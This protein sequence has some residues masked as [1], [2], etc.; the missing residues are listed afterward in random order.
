MITTEQQIIT[1]KSRWN[2]KSAFAWWGFIRRWPVIPVFII[3]VMIIVGIF[4]PVIAPLHYRDQNLRFAEVPPIWMEDGSSER[5]LGGDVVG[6]D[7]LSRLIYGARITL[8]ISAVSLL[9]GA[10][11]GVT[12][13]LVAGYVGGWTDEIIMRVVDVWFAIP[14]LLLALIVVIVF[15]PSLSLILILLAFLTWAGFVRNIRAEVLILKNADYVSSA[16]VSG[17]S[18]LRIVLRHMLPGVFNTVLVLATLRVG[19]L[20]LAEASLSFL[21]AGIPAPTPAWGGMIADGRDSLDTSWWIAAFPGIAIM[22]VVMSMNFL[23]DWLRDKLDPK[24]RQV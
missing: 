21:G 9:S 1:Q 23:G 15:G 5:I 3:G 19:S 8:M 12:A 22:L 14:F 11:I 20:I 6:R 18:V 2:A 13:G 10:V 4:A 7:I 17:G 24:L 16:K